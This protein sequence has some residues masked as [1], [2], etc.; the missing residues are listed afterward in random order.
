MTCGSL[1]NKRRKCLW[2][3]G[4]GAAWNVADIQPG[5][6]VAIFGL[7]AVGLAV[8]FPLVFFWYHYGSESVLIGAHTHRLIL[9]A[10]L[11][12]ERWLK[13]QEPGE[14]LKSLGS[15]STLTSSN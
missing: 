4:V 8:S 6:T 2:N 7:G 12:G 1:F 13:V 9:N 10:V 14:P 3:E 15:T 5:A 11:I